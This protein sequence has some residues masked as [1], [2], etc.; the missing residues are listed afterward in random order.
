MTA[1]NKP[2]KR[3]I[4][5]FVGLAN[6][7]YGAMLD[8]GYLV[9]S[10]YAQDRISSIRAF[11]LLEKDLLIMLDYI[12]PSDANLKVYSHQLYA[13]LLRACTEFESNCKKVLLD[14]GYSSKS[15]S[16]KDYYKLNMSSKLSEYE[17][18]LPLWHGKTKFFRPFDTW[19][20]THTLSWYQNYNKVKHNR[21]AEFELANL[22]N[23]LAAISGVFVLLFSQFYILTFQAH[24]PVGFWNEHD[25]WNSHDS[26]VF[27]IKPP[28]TWLPN[29]FYDFDWES[30]KTTSNPFEQFKFV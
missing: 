27:S 8:E 3:I 10:R 19:S 21:H 5:P 6:N 16:V 18:M 25:G 12:E 30:L 24:S 14:N 1:L 22:E 7:Y 15:W 2:L 28:Q 13:L 4:R 20:S 23:V 17:V 11:G 26:S 29:E 9:D